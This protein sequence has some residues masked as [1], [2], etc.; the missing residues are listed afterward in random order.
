MNPKILSV[1]DSRTVRIIIRKAFR[2]F[3]CT[4]LEASNGA[5]GLAVAAREV[6]ALILLDVTM[7]GM[8]GLEMLAQLRGNPA[9]AGIPVVMLTAEGS[10]EQIRRAL[11]IGAR[12]YIAKPFKEEALIERVRKVVELAPAVPASSSAPAPASW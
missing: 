12:D 8:D 9:L 6:P 2:P 7:P 4:I 10:Q 3:D 11:E 1:D 5:E